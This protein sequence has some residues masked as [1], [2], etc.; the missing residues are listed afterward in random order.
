MYWIYVKIEIKIGPTI[1][2]EKPYTKAKFERKV[3]G[4][5]ENREFTPNEVEQKTTTDNTNKWR[6]EMNVNLMKIEEI[7]RNRGRGL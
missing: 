3:L 1:P 5:N 4:M 6:T 7:E 2:R